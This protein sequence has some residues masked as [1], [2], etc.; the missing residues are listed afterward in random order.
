MFRYL[1]G[2]AGHGA[3]WDG[4]IVFFASYLQ[5]ALGALLVV[6]ALWPVR[7]YLMFAAAFG[8]AIIARLAIKPLIL[9]FVHRARPYITLPDAH[10]I[11]GPQLSEELQSMPSGHALFFFGLAMAVYR[12]NKRW[13]IVFFVGALSMGITRVIGGIHWPSDILGGALIGI[14][15]GWLTIQLIPSFRRALPVQ[16]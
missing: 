9:L 7:R 4:V 2:L 16:K 3:L 8:A 13:G 12:Y 6:L 15:V 11:I 1:N 10:N 5:Y 14:L